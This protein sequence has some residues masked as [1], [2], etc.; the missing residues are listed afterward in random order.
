MAP[1]PFT[2][3]VPMAAASLADQRRAITTEAI[4]ELTENQ[5]KAK[6]LTTGRA[7]ER[8]DWQGMKAEAAQKFCEIHARFGGVHD[9]E[10]LEKIVTGA[11]V[12]VMEGGTAGHAEGEQLDQAEIAAEPSDAD[13]WIER[14]NAPLVKREP[15]GKKAGCFDI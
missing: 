14:E 6:I 9:P 11:M 1:N 2:E 8:A 3:H 5:I 15:E 7:L 4:M 12:W 13:H 10:D